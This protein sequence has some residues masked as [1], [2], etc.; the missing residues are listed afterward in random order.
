M[1]P[2]SIPSLY[3]FY[4][5]K[6]LYHVTLRLCHSDECLV[7]IF[8]CK[9]WDVVGNKRDESLLFRGACILLGG[10]RQ[11]SEQTCQQVVRAK[12]EIRWCEQSEGWGALRGRPSAF[13]WRGLRLSRNI[14]K[15]EL[16]RKRSTE[17]WLLQ[18]M[19]WKRGQQENSGTIHRG[20][21]EPGRVGTPRIL[22]FILS[23]FS[24]WHYF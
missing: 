20:V 1:L 23:L 19:G 7:S 21:R 22:D 4:V 10:G 18:A 5:F 2:S 6:N 16:V 3:N 8:C 17:A 14:N 24:F 13:S 11:I 15:K 9:R 12:R